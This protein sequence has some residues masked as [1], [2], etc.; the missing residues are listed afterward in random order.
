MHNCTEM[1]VRN[2][3]V[4]LRDRQRN[5]HVIQVNSPCACDMADYVS[6]LKLPIT[7]VFMAVVDLDDMVEVAALGVAS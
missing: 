4:S 5:T 1:P 6:K 3:L 7:P 2:Y